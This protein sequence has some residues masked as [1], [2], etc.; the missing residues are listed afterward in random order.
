VDAKKK[1]APPSPVKKEREATSFVLSNPCRV[2][3]A[4]TKYVSVINSAVNTGADLDVTAS[5][6]I[7]IRHVYQHLDSNVVHAAPVGIVVLTDT[8]PAQRTGDEEVIQGL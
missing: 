7:P 8:D 3:P 2:T 5:R 4:Q 6:Y 1:A